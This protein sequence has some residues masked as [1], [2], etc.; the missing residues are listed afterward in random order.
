MTRKVFLSAICGVFLA[1]IVICSGARA[2]A[3]TLQENLPLEVKDEV[4]QKVY[5][6]SLRDVR[7]LDSPFKTAMELDARYLLSLE[8]D[9]FLSRFRAPSQS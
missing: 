2:F 7:L 3:D 8:A 5:A 6:F 1:V 9:R 4:P